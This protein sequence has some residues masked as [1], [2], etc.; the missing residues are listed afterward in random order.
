MLSPAYFTFSSSDESVATVNENGQLL[1]VGMG[2]AKIT[3]TI[4]NNG[5]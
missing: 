3:A 4:W 1:V 2:T 5:C